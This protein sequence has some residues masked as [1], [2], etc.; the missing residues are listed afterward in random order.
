LRGRI[1]LVCVGMAVLLALALALAPVDLREATS[2]VSGQSFEVALALL[3]YTGA[4]ILRATS[5]RSLIGA[6]VPVAKLFALLIGALCLNHV[7]PAKAGDMARMYS[8]SRWGMP[9]AQ[10]V[11]S[12]VLS[13]LVE[14]AG[15]LVVLVASLAL[16]D[17]GGWSGISLPVLIFAGMAVALFV[18]ARLK[19]PDSFGTCVGVLGRC[20]VRTQEALRGATWSNLFRSLAFAAPAWVLE[21]GILLVV[22]RGLALGLSFAE[23]VAANCFAVL[24]AAV[25][26]APGSVGTYEAGMVAALLVF[27]V[28]AESAFVAAVATHAIKFLYA[29]A[30]APFAFMEGLEAVR[31][32]GEEA[33]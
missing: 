22:G 9:A 16:A 24:V 25:P 28:P 33:R 19:L 26:L 8:L 2:Y 23:I 6:R 17:S 7:A 13:R 18:L 1:T 10:A 21:A 5:W 15:L 11:T 4:F 32:K 29:L 31:K 20:V 3:S 14:L 12:V 30:A 27:G